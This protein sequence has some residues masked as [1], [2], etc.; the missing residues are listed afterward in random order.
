V[1]AIS[2]V[3]KVGQGFAVPA[4]LQPPL[5]LVRTRGLRSLSQQ[6]L[7]TFPLLGDGYERIM[8]VTV[9]PYQRGVHALGLG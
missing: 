1:S 9:Q 5:H 7:G 6:P 4:R 2:R 3:D 8:G